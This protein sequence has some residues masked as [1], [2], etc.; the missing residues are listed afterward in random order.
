MPWHGIRVDGC[1]P[2]LIR[3][4]SAETC[5]A[6]AKP[7][8]RPRFTPRAMLAPVC[9]TR[10]WVSVGT[11]LTSRTSALALARFAL[12]R[13]FSEPSRISS[14]PGI[15]RGWPGV[16]MARTCGEP[17]DGVKT[18]LAT[19]VFVVAWKPFASW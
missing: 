2:L 15:T 4:L 7:A 16:G 14:T 19:S 1:G 13:R 9:A 17:P 5:V 8:N 11:N 12:T 6:A 18:M 10:T 3:L